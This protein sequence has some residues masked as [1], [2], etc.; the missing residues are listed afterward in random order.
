MICF[1]RLDSPGLIGEQQGNKVTT[2]MVVKPVNAG[3]DVVCGVRM[4]YRSSD[5][6]STASRRF[7]SATQKVTHAWCS[8]SSRTWSDDRAVE[9]GYRVMGPTNSQL[10][11]AFSSK[12][13]K[14]WPDW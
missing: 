2:H 12:V 14:T 13:R 3:G 11:R 1:R 8:S 4:D 5:S 10:A 7:F 6:L 9:E